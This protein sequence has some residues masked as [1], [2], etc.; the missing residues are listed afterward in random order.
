MKINTGQHAHRLALGEGIFTE[1]KKEGKE[2][3]RSWIKVVFAGIVV[4]FAILA[5]VWIG[6][7]SFAAA[8]KKPA[9]EPVW[10]AQIPDYGNLSGMK[11]GTGED[12]LYKSS[13]PY[14]RVTVQKSSAGGIVTRT[15]VHFYIYPSAPD[16]LVWARFT[17]V[18]PALSPGIPGPAGAC[19]FPY[20]YNGFPSPDCFLNFVNSNHPKPGY[21]H[22]LFNFWVDADIDDLSRFPLIGEEIQWTGSGAF[23]INIWNSF[24]PISSQDPEP[25]HTVVARLNGGDND[26]PRGF[27]IRRISDNTWEFRIEQKS[28]AFSQVYSWAETVVGRNGKPSTIV[29]QYQPLTGE[30]DLSLKLRLIKNPY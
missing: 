29:T 7:E 3:S 14:V 20:P 16:P 10:A 18:Y 21:D 11:T 9:P 22:L 27:F 26:P 13:D 15:T 4:V 2:M 19:G 28:F 1:P 5:F 8:G 25:Y 30:G 23:T 24:E 6:Q 12:Y 17:G